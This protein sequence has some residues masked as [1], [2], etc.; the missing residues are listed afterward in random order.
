MSSNSEWMSD[1]AYIL[2]KQHHPIYDWGKQWSR[3]NS[4]SQWAPCRPLC[5]EIFRL[6]QAFVIFAPSVVVFVCELYLWFN[7]TADLGT[8]SSIKISKQECRHSLSIR[9]WISKSHVLF[10]YILFM[11]IHDRPTDIEYKKHS[12]YYMFKV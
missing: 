8:T 12:Q 7:I 2:N 5:F 9:Q 4:N 11:N 1:V 6:F 3:T 10:K